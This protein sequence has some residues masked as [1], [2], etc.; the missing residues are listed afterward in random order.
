ME[1]RRAVM[2]DTRTGEPVDP[3][4]QPMLAIDELEPA[5]ER[6]AGNPR[7]HWIFRWVP[8]TQPITGAAVLTTNP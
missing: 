4:W 1:R 8:T 7:C 5:N 6:M 2:I 3:D